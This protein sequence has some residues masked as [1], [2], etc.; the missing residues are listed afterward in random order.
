[1]V[2]WRKPTHR[3]KA[4]LYYY[5][6]RK[7]HGAWGPWMSVGR[8]TGFMLAT[9]KK[10]TYSVKVVAAMAQTGPTPASAPD[11]RAGMR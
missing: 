6:V 11:P 3:A 2:D 10:G 5:R 8:S 1:M 7:P 4:S 9:P